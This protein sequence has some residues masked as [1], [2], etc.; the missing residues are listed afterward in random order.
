MLAKTLSLSDNSLVENLNCRFALRALWLKKYEL[1]ELEFQ[2]SL[3]RRESIPLLK[4][5]DFIL[6]IKQTGREMLF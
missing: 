6:N 2:P 4:R 3:Q 1:E 5:E